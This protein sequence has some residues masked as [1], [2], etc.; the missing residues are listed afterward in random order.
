METAWHAI[1]WLKLSS[2]LA[3]IWVTVESLY[4]HHASNFDMFM[5]V[6]HVHLY[7]MSPT[8]WY[9]WHHCIDLT[10]TALAL[11]LLHKEFNHCTLAN[12]C[13]WLVKEVIKVNGRKRMWTSE[14]A[15][16]KETNLCTARSTGFT[17]TR[18]QSSTLPWRLTLVHSHYKINSC[19]HS[20]LSVLVRCTYKSSNNNSTLAFVHHTMWLHFEVI[21]I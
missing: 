4:L 10:V 11:F 13:H 3:T 1:T 21:S 17:V 6:H 8:F 20:M 16:T 12:Q 5:Y 7:F 14:A 9:R 2:L 18:C 15:F 19:I